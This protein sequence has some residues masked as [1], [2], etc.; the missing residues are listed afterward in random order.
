MN[1]HP[2]SQSPPRIFQK[3]HHHHHHTSIMFISKFAVI[4]AAL[5]PL[6]FVGTE[7]QLPYIKK[8]RIKFKDVF[9]RASLVAARTGT[10]DLS[11]LDR[12]ERKLEPLP[13]EGPFDSDDYGEPGWKLILTTINEDDGYQ[14]SMS[15]ESIFGGTYPESDSDEQQFFDDYGTQAFCKA[16]LCEISTEAET[17]KGSC[18][19]CGVYEGTAPVEIGE[20]EN[21]I[22][23]ILS[24]GDHPYGKYSKGSPDFDNDFKKLPKFRF[25]QSTGTGVTFYGAQ[26]FIQINPNFT[27]KFCKDCDGKANLDMIVKL[28]F[29]NENQA[30]E[31]RRIQTNEFIKDQE[32]IPTICSER[33][34][35]LV[36][37]ED[38]YSKDSSD[39]CRKK[40]Q[41]RSRR[42]LTK[43]GW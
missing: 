36:G 42:K 29:T 4:S 18:L 20:L 13:F 34:G 24:S 1:Q 40:N 27:E 41:K 31:D 6:L 9:K 30:A 39:I 16:S 19:G 21:F 12:R 43:R 2:F 11:Y 22:E 15:C 10:I 25:T 38:S 5:A 32:D 3:P 26:S 23:L 28:T 33:C 8:F 37:S 35:L 7:A 14:L 17:V